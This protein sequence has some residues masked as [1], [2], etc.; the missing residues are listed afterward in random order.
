M[1]GKFVEHQFLLNVPKQ[2]H[3]IKDQKYRPVINILVARIDTAIDA[4]TGHLQ[5][6]LE[7]VHVIAPR[8]I[9]DADQEP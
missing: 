9:D 4:A 5:E 1:V 8:A 6:V 7:P 3:G 2:S